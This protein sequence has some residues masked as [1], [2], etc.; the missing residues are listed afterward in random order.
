MATIKNNTSIQRLKIHRTV[1]N[2]LAVDET[3]GAN[4]RMLV[5]LL[6]LWMDAEDESEKILIRSV[7]EGQYGS[8]PRRIKWADNDDPAA[9]VPPEEAD[10][11]NQVRGAFDEFLRSGR[12]NDA[13]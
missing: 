13:P 12:T 5:E 3:L 8:T 7:I 6:S 1:M 2:K 9:P 4:R 10:R 11:V